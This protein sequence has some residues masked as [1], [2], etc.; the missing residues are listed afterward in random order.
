MADDLDS[1]GDHGR[2]CGGAAGD[3]NAGR[4]TAWHC[5]DPGTSPKCDYCGSPAS[6]V[7]VSCGPP[8][9]FTSNLCARCAT[10]SFTDCA[11]E[12]I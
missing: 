10:G 7:Q 4:P 8:F 1:L 3:I 9:D 5:S 6:F 2:S 12:F 11:C